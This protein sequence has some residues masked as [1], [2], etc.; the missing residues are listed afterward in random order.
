MLFRVL[1][2]IGFTLIVP[3]I[4]AQSWDYPSIAGDTAIDYYYGKKVIDPF[5]NLENVDNEEIKLWIKN[6]NLFYDSITKN[7]TYRDSV[8]KE[9]QELSKKRKTWQGFPR[10]AGNRFFYTQ[11]GMLDNNIKLL[12]VD[13]NKAP[14]ELFNTENLN[15]KDSCYYDFNYYE[16]SFDGKYIAFGISPNGNEKAT[17]YIVDVEKR[18][19]LPEKIERCFAG[20]IQW[21]PNN[22]GFFYLQQKNISSEEDKRSPYAESKVKYHILRSDPAKDKDIFSRTLN[23]DLGLKEDDWCMI[24]VFPSSNYVLMDIINAS[25]SSVYYANLNDLLNTNE[26]TK[27]E[28]IFDAKD[29]ICSSVL[30]GNH[31]YTFSFKENPNGQLITMELPNLVSKVVYETANFSLDDIVINNNALYFTTL[32]NGQNKLF[33]LNPINSQITKI[34]LP[35]SGG[36][37]L[38][39]SFGLTSFYQPSDK[40]LFNITGYNNQKADYICDNSFTITKTNIAS[41]IDYMP[42]MEIVV[43]EIEIPSYDKESV[44][45]SIVYKKG[46]KFDG[47]NPL[48][49]EAYGAYGNIKKPEYNVNRLVWLKNGGIYAYA[50]V[51]GG[52]EKGDKWYMG[53]FKASKANS[54]KDFVACAEFLIERKYTSPEHLAI[55]GKS[56]GAVTI[57]RALTERP[58]LF[59]A[60]VIYVGTFNPL[61]MENSTNKSTISEFGTVKDSMESEYL[62]NMDPYLHLKNN[63]KYPSVLFTGGINDIRVPFWQ[64]AKGAA[65]M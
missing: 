8:K 52:G 27:W 3:S 36:V 10:I 2:F 9:L 7:I 31:L 24:N 15:L 1:W 19:L 48:F 41:E 20:N 22:N 14:N 28:K 56:A 6:Q 44:P 61:R 51:R 23:K 46:L 43:E 65:R 39:P 57:G 29:K 60:A 17:I 33:A 50:H 5:R 64:P 58:D 53:G 13:S 30:Y 55:I 38:R 11:G 35:V 18:Q 12:C 16:P 42:S 32:E 34:K 59:K 54:W 45:L 25:Y 21:L 26:N 4:F 49:M 40:L 63:T 37:Q 62:L 47:K